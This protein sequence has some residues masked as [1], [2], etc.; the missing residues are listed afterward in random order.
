VIAYFSKTLSKAERNYCVTRRELLAIVKTLEHLHEYLYGQQ[1]HLRTD[2]SAL[3]WL[4][5]FKNIEGQTA[6]RIERLQEYN[7][8]SEHR[9][10][11]N[12]NTADALSRRPCPEGCSH[13]QKIERRSE[14]LKVRIITTAAADGWDRA[15]LRREQLADDE[16]EPL[17]QEVEAGR[18]PEWKDIADRSP[19]Y[20]G[21]GAQ[22]KSLVERDGVLERFWES[23]D[24]RTKTAQVVIPR[25][26]V[27]E[28]LTEMHGGPS[29][30]HLGVWYTV[31]D[32]LE[33]LING[34]DDGAVSI[35]ETSVNI[36]RTT[37]CSIPKNL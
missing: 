19:T 2:H 35:S 10:G 16:M 6:R 15:S 28:V 1:F 26:K 27:K 33:Q 14:S 9:Q 4:L 12:H 22:W 7:F 31:A 17:L 25:S 13:C 11:R 37:W 32:I 36:Y 23:V 20:K 30:G 29:G 18:R 5:S 8:T 3:T 21:Y 34:L 24:G